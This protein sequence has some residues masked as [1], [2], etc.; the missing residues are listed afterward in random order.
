[1]KSG[2]RLQL[3]LEILAENWTRIKR[4]ITKAQIHCYRKDCPQYAKS[5]DV[6][7]FFDYLLH[8]AEWI[9][10][11]IEVDGNTVIQLRKP[12]HCWFVAPSE[13]Q[14]IRN[15]IPTP[16]ITSNHTEH[17]Q[18]YQDIGMRFIDEA[19]LDDLI[20][21]LRHLPEY[22]PDP[23]IT[24]SSGRRKVSLAL[25][26]FSR[27][28]IRRINN[29][30]NS[31]SY[32]LPPLANKVPLVTQVDGSLRYIA[33]TES[34][35][36]ANDNYH[37]SHWRAYLPFVSMDD[38]WTTAAR[39]LGLKFIS[40]HVTESCISGESFEAES[41][42]LESHFKRARPYFLAIVNNQR[43]SATQDVARY[44]SNLQIA[45]VD[46]L[47]VHRSLTI[48]P[49]K[50]IPDPEATVYLEE[51][52]LKR[53]G[54]AG[55]SPR[56]GVLYVREGFE[57]NY[58][59]LAGPIAEY[60]GIPGLADA[61]V[62]LLDRGGKESRLRFLA[63]RKLS[64]EDVT[65]MRRILGQFGVSDEPDEIEQPDDFDLQ[66][67]LLEQLPRTDNDESLIATPKF[68]PAPRLPSVRPKPK[69]P[70][71]IEPTE[72][73]IVFPEFELDQVSMTVVEAT[74]TIQAKSPNGGQG[75]GS[76][77]G[78]VNWEYIQ[79]LRDAY[80]RRGEY[81]V[82]LLEL[83][84]LQ[85]NY[86]IDDP[87]DYVRWLREEGNTSADHDLESKDYINDEWVDIFIEV[88]ATPSDDFRFPMSK[89][90][91]Q[92]AWRYKANYRLYRV[93]N[94]ASATPEVYI[95]ENP[96]KLWNEGKALIEPKDTY[97]TLPDPRKRNTNQEIAGDEE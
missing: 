88:K 13:E 67:H 84:R 66:R 97:I 81:L 34:A 83:N 55:Q 65:D 92:C 48:T 93:I 43:A 25:A 24:V 31:S 59:I 35:F 76:G 33:P 30:L 85:Q 20:D 82:K 95:F 69:P 96:Y 41:S 68:L 26:T 71:N 94:I 32:R 52:R 16:F 78:S 75:G 27:W 39:Y 10:T 70:L 23:E 80:G 54:S 86:G 53:V 1:M 91:L 77:G 29:L 63:T 42:R 18:F 6:A 72:T 62:V 17:R 87:E 74:N 19:N 28:V 37:A 58:D 22:Y 40:E 4:N 89:D 45:V 47:V 73:P 64:E 46:S 15:L 21:L 49:E 8:N 57:K 56:G 36:F 5:Q 44:L 90:E 9:P 50:V 12:E 38:N 7:S 61:F 51:K 60:I 14:I 79:K 3:M 11:Q 2:K